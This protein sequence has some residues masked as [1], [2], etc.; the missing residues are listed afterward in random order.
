LSTATFRDDE[1]F[2]GPGILT[3]T[4]A[5]L[6]GDY[7]HNGVVDAG[8]YVLWRKTPGSYGGAGGYTTWRSN[9]SSP[10]GSGSGLSAST[11]PEPSTLFLVGILTT[12][13]LGTK[14]KFGNNARV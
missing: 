13:L 5:A 1:Y 11:V 4:P 2:A 3:V 12:A 9:F 6:P 14:R 7:N 8:D 10:P